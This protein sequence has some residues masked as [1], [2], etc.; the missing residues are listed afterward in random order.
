MAF[1]LSQPLAIEDY[2]EEEKSSFERHEYL[3]GHVYAMTGGSQNHNLVTINCIVTLRQCLQD[4][5]CQVF[6]TDM[7]VFIA[8]LETFYYP[9][10]AITCQ[11]ETASEYYIEHPCLIVEVLS[12]STERQDRVEKRFNYRQLASLQEYVLVDPRQPWV[13]IDRR[14]GTTWVTDQV[15]EQGLLH[16]ES[17]QLNL[18]LVE[19]Y[20]GIRFSV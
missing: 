19:I 20:S 17:L 7:K 8:S 14:Q 18:P 3:A 16:L 4:S 5:A 10:L 15:T 6:A 9:D 11:P 2:L 12:P 13:Q 1:S